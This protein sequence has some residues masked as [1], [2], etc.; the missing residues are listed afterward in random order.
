MNDLMIFIRKSQFHECETTCFRLEIYCNLPIDD[1][2]TLFLPRS[3]FLSSFLIPE[4]FWTNIKRSQINLNDTL[5][6]Q[7]V[8]HNHSSGFFPRLVLQFCIWRMDG[9]CFLMTQF[10][11]HICRVLFI[12]LFLFL[13]FICL[14]TYLAICECVW[15]SRLL[16][17][18][19][20]SSH[21]CWFYAQ[22]FLS[23]PV[24]SVL[25]PLV[26]HCVVPNITK[27]KII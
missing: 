24:L 1:T 23:L 21:C 27:N 3:P 15:E 14:F 26:F 9:F 5:Y 4:Y 10:S 19:H 2:F 25:P 18:T 6:I 17:H 20:F 7:I 16:S 8:K 11:F 12:R 13:L 22:F